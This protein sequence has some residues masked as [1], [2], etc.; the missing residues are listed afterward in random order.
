MD[1]VNEREKEVNAGAAKSYRE[2]GLKPSSRAKSMPEFAL[3]REVL[4][5]LIA[6]RSG[7]GHFA[8][9]HERFGHDELDL[10]CQCGKKRA[11]LHLF[12]CPNARPHRGKLLC[13]KLGRQLSPKEVLGT[14]EGVKVFAEWS[15]ATKL[16]GRNRNRGAQEEG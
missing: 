11:Q 12:S 3:Q 8:D 4:G 2:L 6:A 10:H 9:Y 7:H 5:W 13:K 1:W 15:F 14:P 16:F